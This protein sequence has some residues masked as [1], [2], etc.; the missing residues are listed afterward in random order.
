MKTMKKEYTIA[1]IGNPNCGKTTI[2]NALTGARQHVG[3]YPGVTVESK[4]GSFKAEG[5][6][7][8]VVDL[9][10]IYSLSA[11]SE[12]ERI[13][14]DFIIQQKP[15]IVVDVVDFS[16]LERNL[17]LTTQ[18]IELD[19]P[20]ILVFNMSDIVRKNGTEYD[21]KLM[22]DLFGAPIVNTAANSG[23]GV[24]ELISTVVQYS[25]S[26]TS[27]PKVSINY[28]KEIEKVLVNIEQTLNRNGDAGSSGNLK[29]D[30]LKLLEDD[31]DVIAQHNHP[32]V[33]KTVEQG[34][35]AIERITNET[36]DIMIVDSRYGFV[37]GVVKQSLKSTPKIRRSMSDKIDSVLTNRLLGIPIFFGL[38][39][40]VF[41][42][43]FTLG[44]P[45]MDWI[46]ALFGWAGDGISGWCQRDQKVL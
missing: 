25:N 11:Q 14:R 36:P 29:W 13:A 44:G 5:K 3:N 20:M 21:I 4:E 15:D 43:T 33:R 38:M 8:R 19:V 7:F 1:L 41:H 24:T 12:D 27:I 28:G 17:Y 22:S 10:G 42:L 23:E 39:Y 34:I 6:S 30:A 37:S 2:F 26:P 31:P 45:P 40:L 32:K 18:L 46:E 16:N 35:I 9:P